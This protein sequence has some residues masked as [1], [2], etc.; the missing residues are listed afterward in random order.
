[1]DWTCGYLIASAKDVSRF[2]WDLLGP[3]RNIISDE[4]LRQQMEW[5]KFDVHFLVGTPYG[6]GL[7]IENVI[8]TSN[9]TNLTSYI[10][11]PGRTFG[12]SSE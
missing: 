7:M 1:M 4:T 5:S 8:Q 3:N 12:F 10:G 6:G 9:A 2:F 11:H